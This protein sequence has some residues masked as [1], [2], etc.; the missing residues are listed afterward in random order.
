MDV[1]EILRIQLNKEWPK[2]YK[3]SRTDDDMRG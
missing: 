2:M 3:S 1:A